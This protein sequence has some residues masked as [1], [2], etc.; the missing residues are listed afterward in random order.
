[1]R[2]L[3]A[4]SAVICV[5]GGI[6]GL[7]LAVLGARL[8]SVSLT[9]DAPYWIRFTMDVRGFLVLSA[10]C[11]SGVLVFGLAPV[12]HVRK[13]D[14]SEALQEGGR[15]GTGGQHVRRWT[16]VLLTGEFAMTMVLLAAV[17]VGWRNFRASDTGESVAEP[18]RLLTV[19]IS[20]PGERYPT[21]E[22]RL[23]A[24]QQ[25][26]E[27][28]SGMGTIS[29]TALAS[30]LPFGGA[31]SQTLQ[32]AG[33]TSP[34][35]TSPTVS[36][37]AVSD[38]YFQTIGKS[39]L[40]G[41]GF[42]ATDGSPGQSNAIVNERFANLYFPDGRVIGQRVRVTD[43]TGKADVGDGWL[44]IV[45]LSPAI[46]QRAQGLQPDPVVYVPLRSNTPADAVL[47]VRHQ[48]DSD[49]LA[50][51]LRS[52]VRSMDPDLPLYNVKAMDTVIAESR[53]NGRV[54]QALV[55]I[56]AFI[57]L[58]LSLIGLHAITAHA[59]VQRT[60]EIGIRVTLGATPRRVS[61]MVLRRAVWQLVVGLLVGVVMTAFW[62]RLLGAPDQPYKMTDPLVLV[63]VSLVVVCTAILACLWPAR[64]AARLD[65]V[66]ALRCE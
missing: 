21:P 47:L 36:V 45:G 54:S 13:T 30:T 66:T 35:G 37:V 3:A 46:R 32:I 49:A 56:I 5:L 65:P 8:L 27:R 55:T 2:Q 44:T 28:L 14:V 59:I 11:L 20:L 38:G 41:R 31:D 4:E 18:S 48:S 16:A 63:A 23:A 33:R 40:R 53:L 7:C 57:A 1:M 6:L 12:L 64:W 50:G 43:T 25:L 58:G 10:V 61:R 52:E 17:V 51:L 22:S 34:S 29:S 39:V 62:Q 19:W 60:R 15:S 24:Y 9:D 26:R 42:T